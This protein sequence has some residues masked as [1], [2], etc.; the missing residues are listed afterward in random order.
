MRYWNLTLTRQHRWLIFLGAALA[1]NVLSFTLVRLIPRPAVAIGAAFDV[2]ITVPALYL[3]LI[4]RA[5]LAPLVS[6]L[7][8]CLLGLL[9]ATW[10]A[11]GLSFSRPAIALG[12]E[13]A[14]AALLLTRLR[15]GMAAQILRSELTILRYAFATRQAPDIPAGAKAFTIHR[16]SGVG[17]MFGFLAGVSVMEAALMHLVLARWSTKLAWTLT[18]LSLYGAVWLVAV[19][20]SFALRPVLV[21]DGEWIVRAGLLWTVHVPRSGVAFE[22]PAAPCDLRVPVLAEPNLIM[23]LAEPAIAQGLFGITRKVS[24]I[25]LALDDPA[26]FRE[27]LH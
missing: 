19:A 20:R 27:T 3:L 25:A 10:L 26:A 18:V 17:Q 8:L 22:T 16:E 2:A 4:V 7:P 9:R 24:T 6:A 21:T 11:P 1:I 14:I 13:I 5:G 23:R 12:L 15:N